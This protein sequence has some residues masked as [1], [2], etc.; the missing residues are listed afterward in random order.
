VSVVCCQVEVC[1]TSRSLV[2]RSPTD[3]GVSECDRESSITW[4]PWPTGA[5][6]E[7]MAHWGC[8]TVVRKRGDTCDVGHVCVLLAELDKLKF[9]VKRSTKYTSGEVHHKTCTN[10][11]SFC[12]CLKTKSIEMAVCNFTWTGKLGVPL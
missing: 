2:Q 12:L 6:E 1:A 5:V 3:C 4:R 9:G 7:A 11:L 8:C 10:F